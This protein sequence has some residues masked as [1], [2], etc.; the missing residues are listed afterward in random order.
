MNY[1]SYKIREILKLKKEKNFYFALLL[2]I[3]FVMMTAAIMTYF[4]IVIMSDIDNSWTDSIIP[5]TELFYIS[6]AFTVFVMFGKEIIGL[7]IKIFNW[8]DEVVRQIVDRYTLRYWRK[9]K[10]DPPFL[11]NVSKWQFKVFGWLYRLDPKR[12]KALLMSMLIT[13]G[14]YMIMVRYVDDLALW[15]D[16]FI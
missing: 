3:K 6:S 7:H 10:K 1:I 15:I 16:S 5:Y 11:S 12:R 14:G 4:L 9:H 13:Y 8:I 2:G